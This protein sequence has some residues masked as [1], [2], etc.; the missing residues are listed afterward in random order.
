MLME[1][2]YEHY[3]E[4]CRGRYWDEKISLP[5]SV[6]FTN[7]E[8]KREMAAILNE[9]G[10]ACVNGLNEYPVL[11]I[12]LELKRWASITKPCKHSSV[13]DRLYAYADFLKEIYCPWI[14]H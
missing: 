7:D 8:S 9:A 4:N 10:F 5:Y 1:V 2:Y 13:N 6:K 11:L 3:K 12:N 14:H